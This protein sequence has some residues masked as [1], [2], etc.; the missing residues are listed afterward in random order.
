MKATDYS[1]TIRSI[2]VALDDACS[3][4]ETMETA[5]HLAADL[6]AELQGLYIEDINVLRMAGLPF[7]AEITA[8][9]GTVRPIDTQS[10]ERAMQ[11]KADL[12][13]LLRT[14]GF[15]ASPGIFY[16]LG[17]I[18]F[19]GR[20]VSFAV[21]IWQLI[22][23][24]IAVRAALDYQNAVKAVLVCLIGWVAYMAAVFVLGSIL[25]LGAAFS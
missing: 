3:D 17:I 11:T 12:G 13:Q 10:M 21:S 18:P 4:H 20:V 5:A 16:I 19:L 22:A 1:P 2:L 8:A 6:H 14:T 24:V 15:A 23:M 25:G 9:S 7:M